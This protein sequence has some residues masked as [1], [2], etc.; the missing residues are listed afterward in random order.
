MFESWSG[1]QYQSRGPMAPALV[2]VSRPSDEIIVRQ[3]ALTIW[4]VGRRP[5][6]AQPLGSV[7]ADPSQSWSG[8]AFNTARPFRRQGLRPQ[9]W[10][11]CPGLGTQSE[12]PMS[13]ISARRLLILAMP[14]GNRS[15]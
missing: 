2:L 6:G 5:T 11:G 8:G 9:I 10:Y 13:R 15:L 12:R 7:K 1:R 4:S 3:I 14:G